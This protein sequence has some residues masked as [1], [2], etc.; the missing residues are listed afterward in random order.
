MFRKCVNKQRGINGHVRKFLAGRRA[1]EVRG[2]GPLATEKNPVPKDVSQFLWS[3]NP[4]ESHR[5]GRQL[6]RKRLRI[7]NSTWS[8]SSATL[9]LSNL[10][11]TS[12]CICSV[13]CLPTTPDLRAVSFNHLAYLQRLQMPACK[14]CPASLDRLHGIH[15]L[16]CSKLARFRAIVTT[17]ERSEPVQKFRP[18][19]RKILARKRVPRGAA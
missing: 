4:P 8:A 1:T 15:L 19:F 13:R 6:L 11:T 5:T 10:A 17:G 16:S 9:Q 18:F 7:G 3:H 12:G 14:Y 2:F